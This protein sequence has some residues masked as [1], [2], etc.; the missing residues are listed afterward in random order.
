MIRR[1][2]RSTLFPYTT[3]FRSLKDQVGGGLAPTLRSWL[4]RKQQRAGE[5][6]SASLEGGKK[7]R[8]IETLL[9]AADRLFGHVLSDGPAG[10]GELDAELRTLLE[11]KDGGAK[12][13]AGWREEEFAEAST[14]VR[15]AKAALAS[16]HAFFHE[17]LE[18]LEPFAAQCRQR[19][20]D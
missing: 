18:L 4:E 7:P 11:Q 5:L 8:Q 10:L 15:T 2:P 19:F 12:P 13:P 20:L 16:D 3:L 6:L 1:P 17:L 14:L 9:A